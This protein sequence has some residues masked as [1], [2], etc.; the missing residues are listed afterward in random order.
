MRLVRLSHVLVLSFMATM[1]T[2][3]SLGLAA[4]EEGD[5][6][7]SDVVSK[8]QVVWN[9]AQQKSLSQWLLI[10]GLFIIIPEFILINKKCDR[11]D[12]N[13]TVVITLTLIIIAG[14]FLMT[15]GYSDQQIAPVIGLLGTIV[16]YLL[17]KSN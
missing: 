2:F 12:N 11:W 13:C 9:D 6:T 8:I 16:G 17:G 5:G 1:I 4:L 15:A 10:F 7:A 3:P 14:L